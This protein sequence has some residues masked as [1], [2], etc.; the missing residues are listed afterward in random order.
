VNWYWRLTALL[1]LTACAGRSVP[2]A[3]ELR[4]W[5]TTAKVTALA[6]VVT[7]ADGYLLGTVERAEE[8]WTY[9]DPC[10]IIAAILGRCDGTHAYKLTIRSDDY[11]KK[12]WVFVPA[13]DT[14]VLPVGTQA[15]FVWTWY[16]AHQYALCRAR[17]AMYASSCPTDR[18]PAVLSLDAVAAPG[19]SA[20]V[21]YLFEKKATRTL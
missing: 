21:A 15:V 8:D 4:P 12:L 11:P 3:I 6:G 13:R 16:Y 5:S 14:L 9:D 7:E 10:G 18:L 1:A 20:L 19:D 2:H 17:S